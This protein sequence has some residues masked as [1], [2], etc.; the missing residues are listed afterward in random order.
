MSHFLEWNRSGTATEPKGD[1]KGIE[2]EP[3]G[4][5]KGTEREPK[6][7]RKRTEREPKENRKGTERE[8]KENRKGTA[9]E[10]RL[11]VTSPHR[12]HVFT[13]ST[14]KKQKLAPF[15]IILECSRL[16]SIFPSDLPPSFSGLSFAFSFNFLS[17]SCFLDLFFTSKVSFLETKRNFNRKK[18]SQQVP[19]GA[20]ELF[21]FC[22]VGDI[23]IS[24]LF[25]LN[26]KRQDNNKK[27]K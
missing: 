6:K 23:S 24:F 25:F 5:R 22:F 12:C 9:F 14:T 11:L 1:R 26:G 16:S 8:P 3:K 10:N 21:L 15:S 4:N 19:D 7:N 27:S 2:R 18:D 20:R 13:K 17:F